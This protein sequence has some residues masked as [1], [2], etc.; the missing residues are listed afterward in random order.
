[1]PIS[2]LAGLGGE[3][4][5]LPA[6]DL[7]VPLQSVSVPDWLVDAF[8]ERHAF[9]RKGMSVDELRYTSLP[10]LAKALI[11]D[12]RAAA[13]DVA[14]LVLYRRRLEEA[15]GEAEH[16]RERAKR[17]HRVLKRLISQ[18]HEYPDDAVVVES[19]DL[20][21]LWQWGGA[22]IEGRSF[23]LSSPSDDYSVVRDSDLQ[24][25]LSVV[26]SREPEAAVAPAWPLDE[27][28]AARFAEVE[29]HV[30]DPATVGADS[31]IARYEL[32]LA[33]ARAIESDLQTPGASLATVLDDLA[34]GRLDLRVGSEGRTVTLD[35]HYLR[36]N[37]T[38]VAYE[39]V[40]L[41]YAKQARSWAD[42]FRILQQRVHKSGDPTSSVLAY[43][44]GKLLADDMNRKYSVSLSS[45]AA[46]GVKAFG[47]PYREEYAQIRDWEDV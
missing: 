24:Q 15:I 25:A 12:V 43:R 45:A 16:E 18:R 38:Y 13:E 42:A 1:M 11:A 9:E 40:R 33:V 27:W 32:Y 46:R 2:P 7:R 17:T 21:H 31:Q 6:F 39:A 37:K 47:P 34:D 8:V 29:E 20:H 35:E 23:L 10:E 22:R 3:D 5:Q 30:G 19:G 36:T 26:A 28:L 41:I 44:Q 14:S 4:G